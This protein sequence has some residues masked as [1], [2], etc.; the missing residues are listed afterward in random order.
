MS[1]QAVRCG[2]IFLS[3]SGSMAI[4]NKAADD[5]LKPHSE[6]ANQ[7]VQL[8]VLAVRDGTTMASQQRLDLNALVCAGSSIQSGWST[9]SKRFNV[10][11]I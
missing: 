6:G 2:F 4:E 10:D 11:S 7:H 5:R 8:C 3:H 9:S 1:H